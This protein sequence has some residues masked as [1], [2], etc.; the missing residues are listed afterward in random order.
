MLVH[1]VASGES[2]GRLE[3]MLQRAAQNQEREV[4]SLIS[5]SLTV[6]EPVIIL[7][8]GAIVLLIVLAIMLPIFGMTDLLN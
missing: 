1:M 4:Q 7:V 3:D 2:S 6:M 5:T 8:M